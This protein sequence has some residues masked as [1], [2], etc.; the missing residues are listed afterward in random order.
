MH[1]ISSAWL[2]LELINAGLG[3]E[4]HGLNDTDKDIIQEQI[5]TL[6]ETVKSV[7]NS[8]V[9]LKENYKKQQMHIEDQDAMISALQKEIIDL[10][11]V[12]QDFTEKGKRMHYRTGEL[13]CC[14]IS[15]TEK[16]NLMFCRAI[17]AHILIL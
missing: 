11:S 13:H 12:Q 6:S 3:N 1:L 17:P 16:K 14:Q 4:K 2:L 9:D 15:I 7:L 10:K 8:L 5:A